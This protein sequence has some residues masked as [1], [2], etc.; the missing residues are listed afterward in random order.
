MIQTFIF[1]RI[2]ASNLKKAVEDKIKSADLVTKMFRAIIIFCSIVVVLL[3]A[4]Y[5]FK[6]NNRI[7]EIFRSFAEK[8][9]L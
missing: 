8:N 9:R 4:Q 3:F 2:L 7:K 5:I 6:R 1:Q